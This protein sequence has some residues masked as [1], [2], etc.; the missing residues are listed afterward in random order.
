MYKHGSKAP[1]QRPVVPRFYNR[2]EEV[3]LRLASLLQNQLSGV[4]RTMSGFRVRAEPLLL[5][6]THLVTRV[7]ERRHPRTYP[8]QLLSIS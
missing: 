2:L 5:W 6:V 4:T 1:V 7:Q 3:D 8:Q